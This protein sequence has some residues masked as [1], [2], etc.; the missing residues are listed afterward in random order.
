MTHCY[1]KYKFQPFTE[2]FS[3]LP[4]SL[5]WMTCLHS[6]LHLTLLH[7]HSRHPLSCKE[8]IIYSQALQYNMIISEN[9]ILHEE[10]TT[11][12]PFCWLAH[13]HNI[14]SLT[15]TKKPLSTPAATCYLNEHHIQKKNSSHHHSLLRHR[16]VI[17]RDYI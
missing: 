4:H 10:L 11:K 7:F 1:S 6:S 9:H 13:I 5:C 14:L 3:L 16:Q 8:G 12:H 2:I 17:Y 15:T